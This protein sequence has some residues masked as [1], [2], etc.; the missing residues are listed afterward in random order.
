MNEAFWSELAKVLP[1]AVLGLIPVVL[2]SLFDWQ[3]KRNDT[4]KRNQAIDTAHKRV[5]FLNDW[6]KAQEVCMP[7]HLG[8]LKQGA[9]MELNELRNELI[10]ALAIQEERKAV[11]SALRGSRNITQRIF[12]AYTP[13]STSALTLHILYYM[14]LGIAFFFLYFGS[15]TGANYDIWSWSSFRDSIIFVGILVAPAMFVIHWWAYLFRGRDGG[16]ANQP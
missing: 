4:Q 7:E 16:S 8:Q 13:R 14:L 3:E 5:I 12:L 10:T 9:S 1:G 11:R 6:I 2:T 15:F